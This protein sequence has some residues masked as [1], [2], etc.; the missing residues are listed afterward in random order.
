M[1]YFVAGLLLIVSLSCCSKINDNK[2]TNTDRKFV[3]TLI[4][5]SSNNSKFLDELAIELKKYPK[6]DYEC[7]FNKIQ[8]LLNNI[9]NGKKVIKPNNFSDVY[10]MWGTTLDEMKEALL[11]L[12]KGLEKHNSG[13][14]SEG[15]T[16]MVGVAKKMNDMALKMKKHLE[17][18]KDYE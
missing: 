17:E 16:K 5:I 11:L 8:L 9:D 3:S 10:S 1:K 15:G 13:Y 14:I 7:I 2:Y 6:M 12:D 4:E 18:A